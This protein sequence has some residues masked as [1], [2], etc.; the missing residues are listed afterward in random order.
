MCQRQRVGK[1]LVVGQ[2]SLSLLLLTGA[3]LYARTLVN[4][5]RINTGFASENLLLFNL[6]IGNAG[7][8]GTRVTAFYDRVQQ[9][10]TAVP[11]VRSVSLTQ[12]PLLGGWMSGSSFTVSGHSSEAKSNPFDHTLIVS[13][14]FFATMGIPVPLGRGLRASD[15]EGAPRVVVVN[16]TLARTYFAGEDPLGQTLKTEGSDW[17]I[18]GV[19]RD[20]MYNDIKAK[21][22]ST[23]Y[24]SFR[25]K[26][27]GSAF[28]T[29][30]T[31]LPPMAVVPAARRV[32]AAIDPNV[33][34]SEIAT[35]EQVRDRQMAKERTFAALC[36]ALAALAVLLSCVGLYGL[37]AYNVARRTGE[38]DIRMALGA[39]RQNIAGPILREA[40]LLAV[41]GMAVGVPAA[42]ALTKLI[43]SQLHGV[44]PNDPL[45][46]IGA[47]GLLIAVAVLAA[48]IPARRAARVDP[49]RALR[50]E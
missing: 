6:D 23:V 1:L 41:Y 38:I 25:Q 7:Y 43:K 27:I 9:S 33:P 28:L 49:M 47:G 2:V 34:L 44:R 11:G 16:E 8:Q 50:N 20:A 36:G 4:L 35:Q 26:E 10:L 14:T 15:A 18:V 32:V 17:Q 24:F 5:V 37:T 3:G 46:L 42:L 30:R 19:C 40:L 13:E 29:L 45:T 48:W 31:L 21:A 12:F 39:T 22:P